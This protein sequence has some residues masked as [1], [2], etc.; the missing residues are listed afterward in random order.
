M[1][2]LAV[3][4]LMVA[5]AAQAGDPQVYRLSPEEIEATKNA[6]ALQPE[7]ASPALL[8]DPNRDRVLDN[9]LYGDKPQRDRRPHGE[10][11]M[12][13]GTGGTRGI[14]GT[15]GMPIGDN[16]YAQFSFENGQYGGGY[17]GYGR[18]GYNRLQPPF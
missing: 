13:A 16:S 12:F 2:A 15:V 9:S 1:R 14:Y 4:L 17:R 5:T 7:S 8:P 10:V 11:G 3:G 18:Y 6:A